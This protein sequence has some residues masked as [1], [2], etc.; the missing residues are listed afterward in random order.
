M[1]KS[2]KSWEKWEKVWI[3]GK[4]GKKW[5]QVVVTWL[6]LQKLM[7]HP[8]DLDLWPIKV[9]YFLWI[10]YQPISVLYKSQRYI[11]TISWEI[12][13]ENIEKSPSL[14]IERLVSMATKKIDWGDFDKKKLPGFSDLNTSTVKKSSRSDQY[15]GLYIVQRQK[16]RH[17]NIQTDRWKALRECGLCEIAEFKWRKV[18]KSWE[19]WVKMEKSGKK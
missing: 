12:K 11:S 3:V 18:G 15:C 2:G 19:K 13:Y 17:T 6:Y 5:L 9:N 8:C 10:D 16:N 14:I 4:S 1:G 7:Y